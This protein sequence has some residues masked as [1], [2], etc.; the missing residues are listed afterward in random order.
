MN[1]KSGYPYSLIKDGLVC[2]YPKLEENIRTDVV[3]L[4]GGISGALTAWHLVEKKFSC[5]VL[6]ARSIGLGSTCASTSLLQYEI[7]V[8]LYKLS[9][10]IGK[11]KAAKA[12]CLCKEAID[13]LAAIAEKTGVTEFKR[14]P[15]L[16]YAAF[17][18]DIP[19]L[20]KEFEARKKAGF[21]IKYLKDDDVKQITGINA[22]AALLSADGAQTN[23]YLFTHCLHQYA[24]KRGLQVF[25]RSPVISIE[26][27]KKGVKLKTVNNRTIFAKKVIHATGYE[28]AQYIEKRIVNLAST[29][30]VISEPLSKQGSFWKKNM[31]IWNT[32]DP[33]LYMRTTADNRILV[34]GRDE[35]FYSPLKR[36]KL[37]RQKTRLLTGDFKKVFPGIEFIPEFSWAGTFG[38]TKDGLPYIGQ[39]KKLPNNYF[40]LGFGGNG[41]TFSIITAE[42]ITTLLQGEKSPDQQL[43]SF[44]R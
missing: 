22:P 18:K 2:N 40:A 25:D 35:D 44:E 42:M 13:K 1:L 33:Y 10:Q 27:V 41:I 37:I 43:F 23:A 4:G 32:A 17:K 12:Y 39:Y 9:E 19:G 29:F 31:L 15:S 11:Q 30:A 26:P 3:V 28:A 24:I 8:P 34:G 36:D 38:S 7:D 20:K 6:D 16:Y 5:V 21:R 14:K